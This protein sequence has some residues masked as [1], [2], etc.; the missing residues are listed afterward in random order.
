MS[1]KLV[2]ALAGKRVIAVSAGFM[3]TAA[4]TADGDLFIWGREEQLGQYSISPVPMCFGPVHGKNTPCRPV[5][6]SV[7]RDGGIPWWGCTS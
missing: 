4:T 7:P 5:P 1:P 2:Q 3:H 6:A